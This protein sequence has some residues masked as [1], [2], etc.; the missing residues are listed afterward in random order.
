MY[1]ELCSNCNEMLDRMAADRG[2]HKIEAAEIAW[3]D[4]LYCGGR[5]CASPELLSETD[6]CVATA[7]VDGQ[8]WTATLEKNAIVW[9]LNGNVVDTW[10]DCSQIT[11]RE[12]VGMRPPLKREDFHKVSKISIDMLKGVTY[13]PPKKVSVPGVDLWDVYMW[14]DTMTDNDIEM[15]G[16]D[17][18]KKVIVLDDSIYI[19]RK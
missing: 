6:D 16:L 10:R 17:T 18:S 12:I 3:R 15:E 2:I 1:P 19:R 8:H 4:R 13:T 5:K 7:V 9:E 14:V 11:F